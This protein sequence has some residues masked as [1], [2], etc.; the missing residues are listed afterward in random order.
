MPAKIKTKEEFT[1]FLKYLYEDYKNNH[2]SWENKDLEKF[3]EALIAYSK[4]I[5]G[6]YQNKGIEYDGSASWQ[7][8]ADLLNGARSYE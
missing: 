4:D 3:L 1:N 7:A 6:F 5:D 8:F 2:D